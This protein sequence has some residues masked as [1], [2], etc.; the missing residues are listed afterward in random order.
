MSK[1]IPY[2]PS[3]FYRRQI[4]ATGTKQELR[5]ELRDCVTELEQLRA[6]V[7]AEGLVPPVFKMPR[8]KICETLERPLTDYQDAVASAVRSQQ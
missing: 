6:W 1:L 7:R 5:D 3:A 4:D 8:R 2:R